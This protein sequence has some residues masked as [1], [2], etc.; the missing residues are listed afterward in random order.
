MYK[1]MELIKV[2]K[3]SLQSSARGRF[4]NILLKCVWVQGVNA[5]MASDRCTRCSS[6]LQTLNKHA[7]RSI[8]LDGAEDLPDEDVTRVEANRAREQ[9]ES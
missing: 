6:H 5:R 8:N 3:R 2:Q 9:E 7:V 1:K 4:P